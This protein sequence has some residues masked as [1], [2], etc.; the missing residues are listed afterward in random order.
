MEGRNSYEP[1]VRYLLGVVLACYRRLEEREELALAG[2]ATKAQRVERAFERR[3]GTV[4]KADILAE[5]P[6]ISTTTVERALADL[7]ARGAIEKV[8]GGRSTGYRR[9]G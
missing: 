9:K 7:L 1:F 6:D 5:C 8:G 3:A 2:R 4:T